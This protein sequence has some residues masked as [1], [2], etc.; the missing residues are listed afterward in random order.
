MSETTLQTTVEHRGYTAQVEWDEETNC[1]SGEVFGIWAVIGFSGNTLDEAR[2]RFKEL[3]DLY[4]E[5]CEKDG[6]DP[7]RPRPNYKIDLSGLV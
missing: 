5:D 7:R 1:Y 3:L 4:L 2:H 6:S